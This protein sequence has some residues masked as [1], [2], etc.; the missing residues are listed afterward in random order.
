MFCVKILLRFDA[1]DTS[2]MSLSHA[3]LTALLEDDLTGY[4]LAKQFD[5]TLGF[6]WR[7]SHQQIYQSLKKLHADGWVSVEEIIQTGKPNK[8]LYS[9]TTLG[10]ET[11]DIWVKQETK[12]RAS[13]DELYVKL[14]NAGYSD[15]NVILSE[16][17]QRKQIHEEK[18]MLYRKIEQ[19][20]YREPKTLSLH[21]RGIYLALA[22]GIRQEQGCLE[23]CEEAIELLTLENN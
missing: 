12:P 22:A 16:I 8:R 1:L 14:Y 4:E 19:R 10:S 21:R 9:L 15:V 5:V 7:A 17:R 6:F 13:K 20:H 11:L 18:L 3:I 2:S 23:W